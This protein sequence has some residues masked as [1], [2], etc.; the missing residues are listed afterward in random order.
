MF[1]IKDANTDRYVTPFVYDD[2]R[3][4][5]WL[6]GKRSDAMWF[7]SEEQALDKI[8]SIARDFESNA[9]DV[10]LVVVH[11]PQRFANIPFLS[12]FY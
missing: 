7:E 8:Q 1:Y 6:S 9:I 2:S 12:K 10:T 11:P 5:V 4:A 3:R